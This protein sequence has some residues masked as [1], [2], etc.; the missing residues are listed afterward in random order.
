MQVE[1][2]IEIGVCPGSTIRIGAAGKQREIAGQTGIDFNQVSLS[3]VL[4]DAIFRTSESDN[5]KILVAVVIVITPV[6]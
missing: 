4:P 2:A 6:G 3:V 5:E 1:P